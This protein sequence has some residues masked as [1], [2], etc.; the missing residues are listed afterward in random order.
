MAASSAA[1][2]GAGE[3][4]AKESSAL[5]KELL[6]V[7]APLEKEL[8]EAI[9]SP[10]LQ[11]EVDLLDEEQKKLQA[12]LLQLNAAIADIQRKRKTAWANLVGPAVTALAKAR[13]WSN[14][15]TV[16]RKK[17]LHTPITDYGECEWGEPQMRTVCRI[18]GHEPW[19]DRA[20]P[21][22]S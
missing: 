14:R 22:A 3:K 6:K 20:W 16:C 13:H 15:E 18:C 5:E 19:D 11:K 12:S 17:G 9:A 10:A 8:S 1:E 21:L 4:G 2:K 7:I